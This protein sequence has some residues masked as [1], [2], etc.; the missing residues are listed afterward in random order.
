MLLLVAV[1]MSSVQSMKFTRHLISNSSLGVTVVVHLLNIILT[2]ISC[3][4]PPF[5]TYYTVKNWE[6]T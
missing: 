6:F 2:I 4:V 3:P 1:N 5:G